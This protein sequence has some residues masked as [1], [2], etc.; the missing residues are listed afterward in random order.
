[1]PAQVHHF[2]LS[3]SPRQARAIVRVRGDDASR[4]L[5]GLLTADVGLLTAQRA[6]P[7]ALLTVKGKIVSEVILLGEGDQLDARN[8]DIALLIPREVID[9]VQTQLEEH[10]IMDDV[11]LERVE[12]EVALCWAADEPPL[13]EALGAG[14]QRYFTTHPAPGVLLIGPRPALLDALAALGSEAVD[15]DRFTA[16]RIVHARPGWGHELLPDHFPPEV[17]FVDAV[18]YDKGCYLGQEPLSR[19]HN[20]GHVNHVMVRVE[21][22]A[23]PS[24]EAPIEL[25]AEA[26]KIPEVGEW[27]SWASGDERIIGLAVVKRRVAEPDTM[28]RTAEGIEV[29]VTSTALGDDPGSPGRK[30]TATVQLGGKR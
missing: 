26:A 24:G 8:P 17:G 30:T 12:A 1:M 15:H 25:L 23:R 3:D 14:I 18:S 4:F 13:V 6:R 28:L 16:H 11:E 10:V 20:R 9:S 7:A 27:T 19:I 5:Q 29:R 2:V 22:S 21:A